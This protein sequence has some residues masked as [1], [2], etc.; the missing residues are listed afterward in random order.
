MGTAFLRSKLSVAFLLSLQCIANGF[1]FAAAS[2]ARVD[3]NR[4]GDSIIRDR[5]VTQ[6]EIL[7]AKALLVSL[8]VPEKNLCRSSANSKVDGDKDD[9]LWAL[10]L[11]DKP[12]S[13]SEIDDVFE[14]GREQRLLE[15][16]EEIESFADDP[17][18]FVLM[19][20]SALG[21]VC[22]AAL[23]AGLTMGM[24][25]LDPLMLLVKIRAS[26]SQEEKRQAESLL[27]VVKQH[28]L[29]LV[30]LL[31]LNSLANEAL[32]L[33]LEKLVSPVVSVLLSVTFI[34]M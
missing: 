13:V 21:C 26:R 15:E 11:C 6:D 2:S 4:M 8:G 16:E 28:H 17:V 30:T 33:F 10:P 12:M 3:N 25:S 22:M 18:F 9:N 32:P 14:A 29:L 19:A 27:P 7:D 34:L 20:S 31:L 24:L 23:A 5:I 1:P